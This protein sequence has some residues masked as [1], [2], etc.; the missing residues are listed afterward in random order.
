MKRTAAPKLGAYAGL[1]ALGLIASLVLGFPE[2]VVLAAPFAFIAGAGLALADT[3]TLSVAVELERDRA[4]EGDDLIFTVR[5]GSSVAVE[6][7]DLSLS[8]PDELS[9]TDGENPV[10][11][12]MTEAGEREVEYRLSCE[13][14]GSYLVGDV[15]VR[16][17]DRFRIFRYDQSVDL[18]VPLKVYP[19]PE[20]VR[21]LLRP[22][23]TQVF[24]GNLVAREKGEGI[25]FADL[26]QFVPGDRVR[27]INWRASAR[28]GELWVNERHAERNSDV[29]LFLDSFTEAKREGESTLDRTV[30]GAAALVEH[31]LEHK[32]RVG[33]VSFGGVLN[34]LLPATGMTQLYRIVDSLL[35]TEVTLNYAWKDI[36]VIPRRTL[37]PKALVIGL[38]PL[39]DERAAGALIDLRARGFDLALVEISPVPF[40]DPGR[41]EQEQI[42]FR[43]W[44]LRREAL[45]GQYERA[46]VP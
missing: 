40:V 11:L 24:T 1:A 4:I 8:I 43:I 34:W 26:R 5:V 44:E 39:L 3:P 22:L 33:L 2:L 18:R 7:L 28:R 25:E 13:R 12:R 10:A 45:R 15:K 37:P 32:D 35:D 38:T 6:Q 21:E 23:E 17:Y 36:D 42:A 41:L 27:R 31:Y 30:R 46:G 20:F 9:L 29:I 14:W 19:R 16:A